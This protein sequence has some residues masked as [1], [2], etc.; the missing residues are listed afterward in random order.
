MRKQP[1]FS[2]GHSLIGLIY[3]FT[4][5]IFL[6][7]LCLL[8]TSGCNRAPKTS[9]VT[10]A[11][12]FVGQ[13]QGPFAT[14]ASNGNLSFSVDKNGTFAGTLVN[15]TTRNTMPLKGTINNGSFVGTF[16]LKGANYTVKGDVW[17]DERQHL[18]GE[19]RTFK[20]GSQVSQAVIDLSRRK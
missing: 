7:C 4:A 9:R 12:A 15:L 8:V 17:V 5:G 11:S 6:A 19:L 18:A 2:R 13:W 16:S 3:T 10:N 14:A 1:S 20:G